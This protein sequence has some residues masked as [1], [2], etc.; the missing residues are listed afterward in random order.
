VLRSNRA[1]QGSRSSLASR[2]AVGALAVASLGIAVAAAGGEETDRPPKLKDVSCQ[3]ACDETGAASIGSI[4]ELTGKRLESVEKV[5]FTAAEGGR[6]KAEPDA[7]AEDSVEVTVPD[8]AA[9]GKPRVVDAEGNKA[10]SP[11]K[12]KIV[13][14][15]SGDEGST[16]GG[17]GTTG[18]GEITADP[19]KG[20][21]YGKK[22]ATAQF[23]V[24][25]SG[26][27]ELEVVSDDG[28]AV[29]S[30]DVEGSPGETAS[31]SWN[32]KT[33]AREVAPNGDYEFRFAGS[34]GAGAAFEQYDH[35]FPV[36]G[37]VEYGDGF[38]A[39]RGHM[40]QDLLAECGKKVAAARGG[41]VAFAGTDGS[42]GNYVVI[43]GKK[44]DTD[45]V[46][47]HLQDETGLSERDRVKTGEKIGRVG[48]TG[49]ASTCH[50]HFETWEG[51]WQGGGEAVDPT[52][53]L[54]KWDKWS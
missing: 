38:G 52:R 40:G 28:T 22:E 36:R 39:G 51:S 16:E 9:T 1:R 7:V 5:K 42:A 34:S 17:E 3:T 26:T 27:S 44:T 47:M 48:D 24:P 53:S 49:N 20:Y 18:D 23:T 19:D 25:D 21:F 46:Y 2:G 31:A 4:V 10:E 15:G 37:K 32:G 41:K 11:V 12:L 45:Y 50:L 13:D 43:D 6:V 8:G 29:A 14:G 33:S 35:I 30:I 54:K